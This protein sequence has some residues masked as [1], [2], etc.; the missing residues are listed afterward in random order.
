MFNRSENSGQEQHRDKKDARRGKATRSCHIAFAGAVHKAANDAARAHH[1]P[2]A[3]QEDRAAKANQEP[4]AQPVEPVAWN[5][6]SSMVNPFML[7]A[8]WIRVYL[9]AP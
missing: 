1:T 5:C 4:A 6:C 9:R 3:E 2:V 8:L 7:S